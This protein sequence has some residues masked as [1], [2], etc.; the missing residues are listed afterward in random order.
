MS[1][2]NLEKNEKQ[3]VNFLVLAAAATAFISVIA[4]FMYVW[5]F[6]TQKPL[7]TSG[8]PELYFMGEI[9][10]QHALYKDGG[11]Y[12]PLDFI[13]AR[14]DPHIQYDEEHKV[15]I[16]T[17]PKNAFY[18]P[19]GA[20]TGLSNLE[21]YTFTYP[22]LE[23]EE[24]IY[25]PLDPLSEYYDLAIYEDKDKMILRVHDLKEP[26]QEGEVIQETK[27]R[28]RP[29]L[30][31]PWTA[32]AASGDTAKIFR[33]ENNWYWVETEN[34]G[35]GYLPE[36][37]IALTTIKVTEITKEIYQPWNPLGKPIILTWEQAGTSTVNP[38]RLQGLEGVQVLSPTWFHLQKDGLVINNADMR[39]VKWAQ[40]QG[41]QVWG[42]FDNGFDPDLT[43]TF[44]NDTNLRIKVIKQLLSYVDMYKLDGINLDFENMY[45]K[46]KAAYV[47]FVRELAPLLHEKERILTVDVTF[48]S[49]SE[50]WSMCYD[51][52]NLAKTA[53]YLMVMAYD[54]HGGSGKVAGSTASIPWVETGLINVL[55]EVPKEKLILGIPFYT[56]LWTETSD[57]GKKSITSKAFSMGQ[58]QEWIKEKKAPVKYDEKT[59]QNYVEVSQE[60]VIY[61]MWLEDEVSLR[62]RIELMK[63]YRLAGAAAWRRGLE[64]KETWPVINQLA[65]SRM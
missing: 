50:N 28:H 60:N 62:K 4:V 27:L 47:Q 52:I 18:F 15:V 17:T 49:T 25:L 41:R 44:L 59:G 58:A 57:N 61:R 2:I 29:S 16:I 10:S 7:N 46:D 21:P 11:A 54:E 65:N 37:A 13:K 40:G 6:F 35:M 14:L 63:K 39:Y 38:D 53:D 51:R 34:G 24:K 48:H 55:E 32:Q 42:L 22:V 8:K 36:S 1:Q 3:P 9:V 19:L 45:L 56:R 12:L 23:E 33:E 43:H 64:S 30:R 26:L 5:P 31:S 20:D